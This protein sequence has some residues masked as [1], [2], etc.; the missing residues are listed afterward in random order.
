VL[1]VHFFD[2]NKEQ[3]TQTK[4]MGRINGSL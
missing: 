1:H 2:S 3:M 4:I